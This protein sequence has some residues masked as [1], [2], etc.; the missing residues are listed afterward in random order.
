MT[1]LTQGAHNYELAQLRIF[2][3]TDYLDKSIHIYRPLLFSDYIQ[4]LA[5]NLHI[6]SHSYRLACPRAKFLKFFVLT[7]PQR[8]CNEVQNL[9]TYPIFRCIVAMLE[10]CIKIKRI[11]FSTIIISD[12]GGAFLTVKAIISG[13]NSK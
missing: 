11:L 6:Y 9:K 5:L 7:N 12:L 8:I 13:I 10:I 3:V 4:G 2:K 1:S